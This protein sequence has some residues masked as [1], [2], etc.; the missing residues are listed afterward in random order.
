MS[1][2]LFPCSSSLI[3]S[4]QLLVTLPVNFTQSNGFFPLLKIYDSNMIRLEGL[5]HATKTS[6]AR[7]NTIYDALF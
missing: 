4:K 2:S 5:R 3:Q 7:I 1:I 6:R